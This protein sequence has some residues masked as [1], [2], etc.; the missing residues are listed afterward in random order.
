MVFIHS[1]AAEMAPC[2]Q[3]CDEVVPI[4]VA[5]AAHVIN[6]ANLNDTDVEIS[7]GYDNGIVVT[8]PPPSLDQCEGV[9][10]RL[11]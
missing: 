2:C 3:R 9:D 5:T 8:Y 6:T 11:R 10:A 7:V 4:E 1:Q